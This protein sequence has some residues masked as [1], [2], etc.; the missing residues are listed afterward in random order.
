MENLVH[1]A[2]VNDGAIV[3][4]PHSA[5]DYMKVCDE[6]GIG[7]VVRLPYGEYINTRDLDKEG[8]GIMCEVA[9]DNI[10]KMYYSEIYAVIDGT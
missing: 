10:D 7:G 3:H 6:N 1:V 8:L 2:S 9:Y 5:Y 4:F